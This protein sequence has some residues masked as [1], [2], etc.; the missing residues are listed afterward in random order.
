MNTQAIDHL[1]LYVATLLCMAGV[2]IMPFHG[3]VV[4]NLVLTAGTALN[5]LAG[6]MRFGWAG[7]QVWPGP[8]M[9]AGAVILAWVTEIKGA[10]I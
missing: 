7:W 1:A 5:C 4:G 8:L 2:A 6:Y 3:I 9:F 10:A